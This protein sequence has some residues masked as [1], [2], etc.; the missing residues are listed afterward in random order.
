MSIRPRGGALRLLVVALLLCGCGFDRADA[1]ES[2]RIAEVL[3]LRPGMAVA[4]VGAG[5]GDWSVKLARKIG[6]SGHLYATEV[7]DELIEKLERRLRRA[8]PGSHTVV[9]G[10]QRTTGLGPGCCDAILVRMVYHHFER[11]EAMRRD[12]WAA[13]R[14]GGKIGIIDIVPQHNWRRLEGV[15]DRGGHGIPI[16]DLVSEMTSTGFEV[17]SQ[18]EE[19]NG[20]DDRYCVVFRRPVAES[21]R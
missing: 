5:D 2:D 13:L 15:P 9:Q 8:A 12:L 21:T 20:D 19:W 4:D 14:P 17:V 3:E 16:E 18:H 7:D 1:A 10:T 6:E 11:P